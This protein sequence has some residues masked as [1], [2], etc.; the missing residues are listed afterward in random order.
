M[1]VEPA[2]DPWEKAWDSTMESSAALRAQGV[3]QICSLLRSGCRIEHTHEMYAASHFVRLIQ[4]SAS[5]CCR[6]DVEHLQTY[7]RT[8]SPKSTGR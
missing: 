7:C 3:Q 4:I 5:N 1:D 8:V 2:N 6:L